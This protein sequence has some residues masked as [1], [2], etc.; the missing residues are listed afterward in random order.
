MTILLAAAILGAAAAGAEPP[1]APREVNITT[2]SAPGWLPTEALERQ[3]RQ[4][5]D[6]FFAAIEAGRDREAYDLMTEGNR[7]LTSFADFAAEQ[8][9][10]RTQAGALRE[11][12]VLKL[13]W[14][15][16]PHDAPYP[17]VYVA[18][19][20]AARY[21]NVDRDCGYVVL[22]Q[23][24]AGGAFEVMR[25]E[26]NVIDNAAARDIERRQ[27]RAALDRMWAELAR[28]CP[29]FQPNPD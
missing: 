12:R 27:S 23:R 7:R 13:T 6:R 18:I 26:S 24:P 9:R 2:D 22:Y 20:V 4:T 19:D 3:A 29:N 8:V 21:A 5:M 14:T 17:G 11:R 15:K 16:D 28:N 1:A 25:T 10:F